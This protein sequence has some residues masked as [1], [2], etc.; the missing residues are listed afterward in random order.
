MDENIKKNIQKEIQVFFLASVTCSQALGKQ[1]RHSFPIFYAGY[2]TNVDF[3]FDFITGFYRR[4]ATNELV[5][6]IPNV[7]F[8]METRP[9]SDTLF[10]AKLGT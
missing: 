7:E 5:A 6:Q 2:S 1:D 4:Y 3:S 10:L 8:K 9:F